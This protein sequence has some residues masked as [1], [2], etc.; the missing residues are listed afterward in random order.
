MEDIDPP[1]E[2]PGADTTILRQLEN[3]GL[4]WDGTVLRQSERLEAYKA[5]LDRLMAEGLIYP[6]GCTRTRLRELHGVYDGRCQRYPV[7]DNSATYALRVR[8]PAEPI[9]WQDAVL[10]PQQTSLSDACGDFIVVRRDGLY[11]YQLAVAIDD[12]YQCITDVI[13][14]S[15]L[16]SSTGRQIHLLNLLNIQVPRYGHVPTLVDSEGRKLSKQ[17]QAPGLPETPSANIQYCLNLL[18]L[19]VPG[20]LSGAPLR[21][22]LDWA[23]THWALQTIQKSTIVHR[24]DRC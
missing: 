6:C 20:E 2:M 3:H 1:R 8:V 14:G 22:L 10:G 17:H 13:R 16:L 23:T 11:A 12:G 7:A 24:P 21:Q 18:G 15:D 9:R 19:P 5:G 4:L